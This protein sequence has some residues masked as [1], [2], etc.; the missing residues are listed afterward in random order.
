MNPTHQNL[1]LILFLQDQ[2]QELG[3]YIMILGER[4]LLNHAARPNGSNLAQVA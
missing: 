3:R 1:T 4:S 2:Y